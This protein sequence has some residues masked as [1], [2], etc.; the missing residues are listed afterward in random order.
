MARGELVPDDVV[1]EIVA[2]RIEQPDAARALFSTA[3]P[4]LPQAVALDRMLAE[5][6]PSL[7]A[8]VELRVDEAA[9]IRRIESRIAAMKAQARDCA[10]TTAP[11]CCT[12]ASRLPGPD[13]AAH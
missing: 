13:R 8:V 4:H 9:L 3:S 5:R 11:R 7:D 1:V 2:E 6:G 12:G 10:M